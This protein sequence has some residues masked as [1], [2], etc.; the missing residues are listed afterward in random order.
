MSSHRNRIIFYV[1]G[2]N[3]YFGL[4]SKGWRRFYWLDMVKFFSRFVRS[5]QELVEVNYFSAKP[6]DKDKLDRQDFLFSANKLN[7]QFKLHLGKYLSKKMKCH[8]CN[9][10]I[11]TFEE[12]ETDVRIAT[13]MISDVVNDRC[14]ISILVSADSDLVPP[15]EFIRE[16]KPEHKIFVYFPPNRFSSNLNSIVD[17][18]RKLDT[19]NQIFEESMLA[20]EILLPNGFKLVRPPHWA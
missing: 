11:K 8:T 3:F 9:T 4:K 14:D 2:F 6:V 18:I 12:K 1:D 19:D 20:D 15:I 17:G 5:H 10:K 7:P 16:H 13:Q